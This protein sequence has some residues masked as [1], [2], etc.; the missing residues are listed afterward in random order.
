MRAEPERWPR[1]VYDLGEEPDYRFSFANERTFLAWIR[2]ALALV[3][4]GVAL[5]AVGVSTWPGLRRALVV[6]LVGAGVLCAVLSW[7]RWARAER[8]VRTGTA[9]P[10]PRAAAVVATATGLVAVGVLA[11]LVGT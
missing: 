5:D 11:A 6:V 8:A 9:L 4:G 1:W 7:F 10:A 2:T 3:A